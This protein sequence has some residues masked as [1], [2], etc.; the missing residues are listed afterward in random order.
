MAQNDGFEIREVFYGDNP[1]SSVKSPYEFISFILPN[2]Y[3][4]AGIILLIYLVFGGFT[5]IR[6]AGNPEG[7]AK[8]QKIITNAI[9]GFVIIFTSYWIIQI[10]EIITGIEILSLNFV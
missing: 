3:T 9:I 5:L 4:I 10:V 6:S 7:A 1:V 8:G 2:I